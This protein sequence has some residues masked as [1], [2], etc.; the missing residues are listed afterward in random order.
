[1]KKGVTPKK[2]PFTLK[3]SKKLVR[4]SRLLE[5]DQTDTKCSDRAVDRTLFSRKFARSFGLLRNFIIYLN[6]YLFRYTLLTL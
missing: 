5:T 3:V 6:F 2:T 1:M 4:S